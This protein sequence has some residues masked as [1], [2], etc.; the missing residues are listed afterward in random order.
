MALMGESLSV[1]GVSFSDL[2]LDTLQIGSSLS[3]TPPD[4]PSSLAWGWYVYMAKDGAG[5][6]RTFVLSGS[7][8]GANSL[9]V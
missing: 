5:S 9:L 4:N 8:S 3:F 7:H 1:S 2:D 6:G